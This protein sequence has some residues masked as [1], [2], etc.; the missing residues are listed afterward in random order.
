MGPKASAG[1]HASGLRM[2]AGWRRW[3]PGR[4]LGTHRKQHLRRTVKT[5]G[6]A[7]RKPT[8]APQVAPTLAAQRVCRVCRALTQ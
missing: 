8:A 3:G 5:H 6:V 4:G 2:E 1:G 7:S